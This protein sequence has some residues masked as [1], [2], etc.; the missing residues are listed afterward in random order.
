MGNIVDFLAMGPKAYNYILDD[1]DENKKAASAKKCHIKQNLKFKYFKNYLEA[2]QLE[3]E[4]N[5][6][7]KMMLN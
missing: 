1:C 4:I 3:N 6:L 5:R 2:N 7:E